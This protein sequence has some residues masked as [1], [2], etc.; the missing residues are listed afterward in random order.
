MGW[1]LISDDWVFISTDLNEW[2]L[3]LSKLIIDWELK[4]DYW[5]MMF[6]TIY[7]FIVILINITIFD[8]KLI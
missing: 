6:I 2:L 8:K 1:E 4:S 7:V 3:I 5:L